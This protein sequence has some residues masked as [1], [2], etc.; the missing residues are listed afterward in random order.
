VP[1]WNMPSLTSRHGECSA[2]NEGRY[3]APLGKYPAAV[4]AIVGFF[5]FF[6]F[7]FFFAAYE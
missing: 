1:L 5:F 7:F 3:R 2:K 6:F 4:K